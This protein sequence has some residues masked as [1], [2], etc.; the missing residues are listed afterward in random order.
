MMKVKMP[1]PGSDMATRKFF[2]PAWLSVEA[3]SGQTGTPEEIDVQRYADVELARFGADKE[4]GAEISWYR[5]EEI[6][7][8]IGLAEL[9][10]VLEKV[11]G[12]FDRSN[13][14]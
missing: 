4:R 10:Q 9:P 13:N 12:V 14:S 3:E 8:I 2:L 6:Q 1:E 11:Y 7:K 5:A